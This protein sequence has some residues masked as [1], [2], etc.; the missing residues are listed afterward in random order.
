MS[1]GDDNYKRM[2]RVT[3]GWQAKEPSLLSGHI[4]CIY[5]QYVIVPNVDPN[6][7]KNAAIHPKQTI[8]KIKY[9][10]SVI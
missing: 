2:P 7:G 1:L 6:V 5:M 4:T 8:K 3:V 9:I 10:V